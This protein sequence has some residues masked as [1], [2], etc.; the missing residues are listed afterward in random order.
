MTYNVRTRRPSRPLRRP[1][2]YQASRRQAV[3]IGC[4]TMAAGAST[5]GLSLLAA[6]A[7]PNG[8]S[9][10][11]FATLVIIGGLATLGGLVC[12]LEGK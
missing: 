5:A 2:R 1:S 9:V 11:S 12:A 7:D 10:L 4:L 8:A 6:V 3:I